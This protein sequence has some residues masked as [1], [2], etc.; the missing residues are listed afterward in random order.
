[1]WRRLRGCCCCSDIELSYPPCSFIL[2]ER[3]VL[4]ATISKRI[5]GRTLIDANA[6]VRNVEEEEE[7]SLIIL[8]LIAAVDVT[9]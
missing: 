3:N 4:R 9:A 8:I 1:M 2:C 7:A 5:W 6:I